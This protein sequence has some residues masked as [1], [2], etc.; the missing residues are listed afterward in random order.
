MTKEQQIKNYITNRFNNMTYEE[1]YD[2]CYGT[3]ILSVL[4]EA[5]SKYDANC[6]LNDDEVVKL[7]EYCGNKSNEFYNKQFDKYAL[8]KIMRV[9]NTESGYELSDETDYNDWTV[10]EAV[11]DFQSKYDNCDFQLTAIKED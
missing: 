8:I 1:Y 6:E 9:T 7:A 10:A 2:L 5:L 11:K 3:G 4:D